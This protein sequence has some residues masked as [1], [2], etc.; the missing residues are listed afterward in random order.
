[1]VSVRPPPR[2][3]LLLLEA[4]RRVYPAPLGRRWSASSRYALR[5]QTFVLAL[6][7]SNAQPICYRNCGI[8]SQLT[9][10]EFSEETLTYCASAVSLLH[11][12]RIIHYFLS[13]HAVAYLFVL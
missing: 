5:E 3:T 12:R 1:M 6:Y 10:L 7:L 11:C 2:A 13:Q 9:L 4:L 8:S